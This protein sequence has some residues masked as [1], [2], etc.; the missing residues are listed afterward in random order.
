MFLTF[1]LKVSDQNPS[2]T[3]IIQ[4]KK[5]QNS[6]TQ[7]WK[8]RICAP[9]AFLNILHFSI[10]R[11]HTSCL[12]RLFHGDFLTTELNALATFSVVLSDQS[13]KPTCSLNSISLQISNS[14]NIIPWTGWSPVSHILGPRTEAIINEGVV[15]YTLSS[16]FRLLLIKTLK[17]ILGKII[18][19]LVSHR[20][21][22]SL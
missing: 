4:E 2:F 11:L 5:K 12:Y 15:R 8:P 10:W 13:R 3:D 14:K 18:P 17:L 9:L 21:Q 16:L 22:E 20:R 1:K 19:Y 6:I 7:Y